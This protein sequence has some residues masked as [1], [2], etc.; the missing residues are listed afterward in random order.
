MRAYSVKVTILSI[1]LDSHSDFCEVNTIII[2][3]FQIRKLIYILDSNPLSVVA[4]L[5]IFLTVY[6]QDQKFLNF[7]EVKFINF[8]LYSLCFS[9]SSQEDFA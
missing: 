3:I 6:F 9:C 7:D 8:F 4:F 5:I 1:L 2:P